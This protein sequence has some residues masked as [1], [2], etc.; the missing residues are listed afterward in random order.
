M[1]RSSRKQAEENR[2]RIVK[3]ATGLFLS[4][5]IEPVGIADV[6]KAAGMTQGG[7]YRHFASKDGL[8]AEACGFA[9]EKAAEI[10]KR[11]ASEAVEKKHDPVDALISFYLSP[12]LPIMT[13]PMVAFAA[14]A[15][16]R[17][18]DDPLRRAYDSGVRALLDTFAE[19]TEA[20][21]SRADVRMLF[22]AM[23]GSNILARSSHDRGWVARFK[24]SA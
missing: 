3:A 17:S 22:A 16:L 19:L 21:R 9:F 6:M 13:C 8:A 24:R 7:F 5:G 12:K 10:W 2:L 20:N 23:V 4:R 1:G 11:V 14:D 15:A 18:T